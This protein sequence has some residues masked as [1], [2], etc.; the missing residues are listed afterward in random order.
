MTARSCRSPLSVPFLRSRDRKR[1]NGIGRKMLGN[2]H[3]RRNRRTKRETKRLLSRNRQPLPPSSC[4][5][6]SLALFP[7]NLLATRMKMRRLH[8]E[9]SGSPPRTRPRLRLQLKSTRRGFRQNEARRREGDCFAL[10]TARIKN[11]G[12]YR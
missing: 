8:R 11:G 9:F 12:D 4:E 2:I 7:T 1:D 3:P 10:K 6:E 5:R